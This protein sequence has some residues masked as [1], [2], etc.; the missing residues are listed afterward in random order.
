M[1]SQIEKAVESARTATIINNT[2]SAIVSSVN[3]VSC[4]GW[5][6]QSSQTTWLLRE[7]GN[8][9]A[10]TEKATMEHLK[11]GLESS[12][13]ECCNKHL[14]MATALEHHKALLRCRLLQDDA[15]ATECAKQRGAVLK[16]LGYKLA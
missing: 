16:R 4:T 13:K 6:H 14:D 15:G 12:C 2:A 5:C 1:N 8:D 11:L 9:P 7:V 10:K 3:T